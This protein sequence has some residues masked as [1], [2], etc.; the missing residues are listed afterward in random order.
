VL[1]LVFVEMVWFGVVVLLC[2]CVVVLLCCCCVV[3]LLCCCVVVLLCC[4]VVV[5]LCC[6]V[7]V[8]LC[9]AF[10][11]CHSTKSLKYIQKP[12]ISH[13]FFRT[14]NSLICSSETQNLSSILHKHKISQN[15]FL[16]LFFFL[17]QLFLSIKPQDKVP[18]ELFEMFLEELR[19]RYS[20]QS[21]DLL[22]NNCNAFSQ[23]VFP[24]PPCVFSSPP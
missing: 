2:C 12:K 1:V 3:V 4:C 11:C 24:S 21:Y 8:L 13:L 18:I 19:P 15:L 16:F 7:V 5:L 10:A 9:V 20:M 14:S 6:C 23:E 22:D 17:L